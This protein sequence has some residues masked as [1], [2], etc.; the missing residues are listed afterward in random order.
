[1]RRLEYKRPKRQEGSLQLTKNT[2]KKPFLERRWAAR[3]DGVVLVDIFSRREEEIV[4]T[5]EEHSVS[6]VTLQF[7]SQFFS[8]MMSQETR[9]TWT[10][11]EHTSLRGVSD[12]V[13]CLRRAKCC[14]SSRDLSGRQNLY[15]QKHHHPLIIIQFTIMSPFKDRVRPKRLSCTKNSVS[16]N[17]K[18]VD[19]VS[20]LITIA[21]IV[22]SCPCPSEIKESGVSVF[23]A[24]WRR[25]EMM[26]TSSGPKGSR[27]C[28]CT[29]ITSKSQTHILSFD[30]MFK[31][32]REIYRVSFVLK[33]K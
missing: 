30:F 3:R 5:K 11:R 20:N 28:V 23:L 12:A 7:V 24:R 18:L 1:M 8:S 6:H 2:H 29:L 10:D 25:E 27:K 26:T 9:Q 15:A 16:R 22:L 21:H 19:D 14:S 32:G 17:L 4:I 13:E 31:R 33:G